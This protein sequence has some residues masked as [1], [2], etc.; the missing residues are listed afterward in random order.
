MEEKDDQPVEYGITRPV[1]SN[2]LV[3]NWC[4]EYADM[5]RAIRQKG[6]L[7]QRLKH[8]WKPPEWE[9]NDNS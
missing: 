2:S 7:G 8:L 6:P 3:V 5:F 1:Y 4:H 9:R